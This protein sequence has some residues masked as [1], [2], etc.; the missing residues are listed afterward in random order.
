[1]FH[2][3]KMTC[4]RPVSTAEAKWYV[5]RDLKRPNAIRRAWEELQDDK[6]IEVFTPKK[7]V[8]ATVNGMRKPKEAAVIPDL[9]FAHETR[10]VL[11]PIIEDIETLQYRFRKYGA[12]NEPLVVPDSDMERF[13]Y[14]VNTSE[15]PKYYLP[16]EI[17]PRMRNRRIRIVGGQLDGYEGAL[18]TIRGSKTKRLLVELKGFLA[19]GVEVNAEYIQ[20]I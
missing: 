18:L 1:M 12:Q 2:I 3:P 13:I 5:L 16:E 4:S 9:L 10:E 8:L 6:K 19:A 11:D 20:L 14:A 17:T 7:W 15:S